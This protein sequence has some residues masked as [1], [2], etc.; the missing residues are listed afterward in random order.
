VARGA[1]A[2]ALVEALVKRQVIVTDWKN[3]GPPRHAYRDEGPGR[4]VSRPAE[5]LRRTGGRV[6]GTKTPGHPAGE[7]KGR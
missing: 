1:L 5:M 3:G 2:L 7:Q 6:P 4:A